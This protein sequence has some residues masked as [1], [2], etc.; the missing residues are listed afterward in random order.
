MPSLVA[1]M[2]LNSSAFKH[3]LDQAVENARTAG[4]KIMASVS[5]GAKSTVM[6][7][8]AAKDPGAEYASFW[9][10]AT[11]ER[12]IETATRSNQARALLRQ[13]HAE[14]EH[15]AEVAQAKAT[16]A[17][18]EKAR[19]S[20]FSRGMGMAA[21][22]LGAAVIGGM[23][24]G[25]VHAVTEIKDLSEQFRVSTDT[26]QRWQIAAGKV[27][28]D[29]NNMGMAFTK[30]KLA[31]SKAVETGDI[32]GFRLFGITMEDI[33]KSA[34][35]A[36]P[37]FEKMQTFTGGKLTDEQDVAAAD[38]MGSKI[39][40]KILS[41]FSEI[42]KLGPIKLI[43]ADQIEQIDAAD[44]KLT[45]IKRRAVAYSVPVLGFGLDILDDQLKKAKLGATFL[46]GLAKGGLAGAMADS[47]A[48]VAGDLA[49]SQ[50]DKPGPPK[51]PGVIVPK[52]DTEKELSDARA[53]LEQ[54]VFDLNLKGLSIDQQRA[55][56][57]KEI[58]AKKL[59][60]AEMIAANGGKDSVASL[61][62]QGKIADLES[63][64]KGMD[65]KQA[66]IDNKTNPD[67]RFRAPDINSLQK[68]GAYVSPEMAGMQSAAQKSEQH[69]VEIR[70]AI[71]EQNKV[72]QRTRF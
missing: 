10:K 28:L 15:N 32:G 3:G 37:I 42:Q 68:I 38:I 34:Q 30:V 57:A 41:A 70:N 55:I 69:L 43:D 2:G 14:R 39:G 63:N 26:V 29:A 13:R 19:N 21:P 58:E 45:E 9:A 4:G 65:N 12:D 47:A 33:K 62:A 16:A 66:K 49:K 72:L 48:S 23:V 53:K 20:V 35:D 51:P 50:P 60:V 40:P 31:M 46:G 5:G 67:N 36:T 64:L 7:P 44:K 8:R 18:V 22:F 54:K 6:N 52:T 56:L 11:L 1:T 25:V 61:E 24:E 17:A 71:T 59:K 27:G